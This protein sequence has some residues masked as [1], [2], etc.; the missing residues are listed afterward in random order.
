MSEAGEDQANA[1]T[2]PTVGMGDEIEAM[3]SAIE[4]HLE[5][6]WHGEHDYICSCG[7]VIS[8]IHRHHAEVYRAA[9]DAY[10]SQ[11]GP[12]RW[13][14]AEPGNPQDAVPRSSEKAARESAAR[15]GAI[16]VRQRCAVPA[17]PWVEA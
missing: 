6:A 2:M 9:V 17:G 13:G 11:S 14:I 8:S 4:P 16:V 1:K 12:W 3:L 5:W 7:E 10:R 15:R